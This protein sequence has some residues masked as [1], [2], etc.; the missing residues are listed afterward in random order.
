M[1]AVGLHMSDSPQ[2]PIS[3]PARAMGESA[4][5]SSAD[6]VELR[7]L[8]ESNHDRLSPGLRRFFLE[9]TSGNDELADELSQRSWTLAWRA[10]SERRYDPARAAYST[11]V[12]AIANNVWLQHLRQLK[13]KSS[14][15]QTLGDLEA[16]ATPADATD[17]L[18]HLEII[19]VL[20][21]VLRG[22]ELS[23]LSD[24]ERWILT[25]VAQG[26]T[27]RGLAAKLRVSASTANARKKTVFDKLRRFL[28]ALGHRDDFSRSVDTEA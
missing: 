8:F 10:T 14:G 20:R 17:T 7:K 21:R 18:D 1:S 2:N 28:A 9:R 3:V 5:H 11:F 27:D 22:E 25:S 19:D 16:I 13:R 26:E 24:Q 6:S 15:T 12:Y 4:Q 23:A